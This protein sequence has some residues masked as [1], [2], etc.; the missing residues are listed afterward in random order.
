MVIKTIVNSKIKSKTKSK[1]KSKIIAARYQKEFE[2]SDEKYYLIIN[3]RIQKLFYQLTRGI[4][5]IQIENEVPDYEFY[6]SFFNLTDFD[7]QRIAR[8]INMTLDIDDFSNDISDMKINQ[9]IIFLSEDNYLDLINEEKIK[10]VFKIMSN[11]ISNKIETKKNKIKLEKCT[12]NITISKE[13]NIWKYEYSIKNET[14][15]DKLYKNKEKLINLGIYKNTNKYKGVIK[16]IIQLLEDVK[17]RENFLDLLYGYL[18]KEQQDFFEN[19]ASNLYIKPLTIQNII[20]RVEF[21]M[22]EKSTYSMISKARMK[23]FKFNNKLYHFDI[24][25]SRGIEGYYISITSIKERIKILKIENPKLTYQQIAK[26]INHDLK[27]DK[28]FR[29]TES[30]I[31]KYYRNYKRDS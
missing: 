13:N 14:L 8:V 15:K 9:I 3:L 6:G 4:N 5:G 30:Q 18:L 23:C 16:R 10:A 19:S 20:D 25:F 22:S 29:L 26:Q 11:K 12:E 17:E 1:L 7:D 24:L 27:L 21:P 2:Y 31:G 28:E